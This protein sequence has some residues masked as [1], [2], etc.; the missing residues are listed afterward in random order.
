M[1]GVKDPRGRRFHDAGD[2]GRA[3]VEVADSRVTLAQAPFE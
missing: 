1:D 3:P 2:L